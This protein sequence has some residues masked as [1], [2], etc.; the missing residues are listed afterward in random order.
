M[1][2]WYAIFL[3]VNLKKK[4]ILDL[5]VVRNLHPPSSFNWKKYLDRKFCL[6]YHFLL[7]TERKI[8]CVWS[9][10][11]VI[12]LSWSLVSLWLKIYKPSVHT[13]C[14]NELCKSKFSNSVAEDYIGLGYDATPLDKQIFYSLIHHLIPEQLDPHNDKVTASR[15]IVGCLMLFDRIRIKIGVWTLSEPGAPRP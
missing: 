12:Q 3:I 15:C 6:W 7:C 8:N 11:I 5:V 10:W 9:M 2:V 14:C 4:L 1:I 13:R